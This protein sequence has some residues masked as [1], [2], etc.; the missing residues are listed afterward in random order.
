VLSQLATGPPAV[1]KTRIRHTERTPDRPAPWLR[2]SNR[3]RSCSLPRRTVPLSPAR[4]RQPV[5]LEK[6]DLI[7]VPRIL[8]STLIQIIYGGLSS[9]VLILHRLAVMHRQTNQ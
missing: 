7:P 3:L 1:T 8:G 5:E 9:Q 6:S 2:R 4:S